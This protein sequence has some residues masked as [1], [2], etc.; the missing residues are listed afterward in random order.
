MTNRYEV[1][2]VI[3]IGRGQDLIL[4]TDKSVPIYDES[5]GQPKRAELMSDEE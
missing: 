3:E 5:P 1:P 2:E 4:G